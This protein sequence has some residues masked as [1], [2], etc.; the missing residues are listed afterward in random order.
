MP[1]QVGTLCGSLDAGSLK[2]PGNYTGNAISGHKRSKWSDAAKENAIRVVNSWPAL[3]IAKQR[4]TCILRQGQSDL[5]PSLAHHLYGAVIPID[6][7]TTKLGHIS[8]SQTQTRQQQQ[9]RTVT[10]TRGSIAI[11]GDDESLQFIR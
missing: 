10:T 1:Q 11:A 7:A 2:R 4:I 9:N 6:I 3:Q 5:I 8:S